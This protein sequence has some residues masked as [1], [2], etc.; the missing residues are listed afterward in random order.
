M[1]RI[2]NRESYIPAGYIEHFRDV[3]LGV[4][5]MLGQ[6]GT[7]VA[8]FSGKAKKPSVYRR[9]NSPER[10]LAAIDSWLEGVRADAALKAE[11]AEQAKTKPNPFEV[12][13]VLRAA[14]GYDQ[15]NVT[16]YQVV[17]LKGR[18]TLVVREIDQDSKPKAHQLSGTCYPIPDRFLS[19]PITRRVNKFDA[20]VIA[21]GQW[22]RLLPV[23]SSGAH[24]AHQPSS[25]TSYA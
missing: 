3:A 9:F 14:W 19:D 20:I 1:S 10:A 13:S 24:V 16:F 18:Q 25:Y 17:E 8:A 12:G 23:G 11:Q 15:T 2:K 4:L 5:V 22:A 7:C 21:P 6:G